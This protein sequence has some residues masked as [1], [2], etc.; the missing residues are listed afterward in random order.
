MF[1][2]LESFLLEA[3]CKTW[4]GNFSTKFSNLDNRSL[5]GTLWAATTIGCTGENSLLLSI[6]EDFQF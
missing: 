3:N 1:A 6:L 2:L 5:L 4:L